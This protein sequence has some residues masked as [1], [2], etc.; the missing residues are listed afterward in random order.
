M[1][2]NFSKH[3]FEELAL[4]TLKY[5][6]K[7]EMG[8]L[9]LFDRPDMQSDSHG[10]EH[11]RC[12]DEY[13]AT[14]DSFINNHFK[15][16]KDMRVLN[17]TKNKMKLH[18]TKIV[19]KN[20]IQ[21][22]TVFRSKDQIELAVQ[23]IIEKAEKFVTYKKF[24][25]NEIYIQMCSMYEEYFLKEIIEMI[26]NNPFLDAINKV[27]FTI[28]G[29]GLF[30]YDKKTLIKYPFDDSYSSNVIKAVKDRHQK[31]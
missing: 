20:I 14:E 1:P 16:I 31:Q 25:F 23:K 4:E 10:I 13:S 24:N 8:T 27:Y 19:S 2:T 21:G 12:I 3:Y 18:N 6:F 22:G 26:K 17:E 9:K 29:T 30:V 5:F 7:N 28:E 11:V 15:K